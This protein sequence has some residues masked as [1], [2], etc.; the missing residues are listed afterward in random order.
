[1][2]K[3]IFLLVIFL[4]LFSFAFAEVPASDEKIQVN[5]FYSASCPHCANV[6]LTL[7][8]LEQKYD[9]IQINRYNITENY[10]LAMQ[11]YTQADI[12][13][14]EMGLVPILFVGTSYYLG[15]KPIIENL[16]REILELKGSDIPINPNPKPAEQEVSIMQLISLALVDAVNP[17][18]L[19]VLVILM[20]AILSR[21]PNNKRK[22]LKA[23]L[24]FTSAIF[25]MYLLF[26]FLI[27][28]GFKALTGLANIETLWFY[29]VLAIVAILLG[30]LNIKDAIWYGGGGFVMEVPQKWRPRMKAIIQGTTSTAGAFV[31]G[32]I[33]SFFL[34]PCT[35]GPYF[36]FGGILS[37]V[38]YLEAI[39]YL[40]IYMVLFISPMLI[41][42]GITYFG[43]MAI[44]DV[45]AWREK[46]I[47]VMHWVA[48]LL[49]LGL[50]LAMW[51]GLI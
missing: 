15:D 25:I 32:L 22:A 13:S 7:D 41:I 14:S 5:F 21:Y 42:T 49:L 29:K 18:E 23:G 39:P 1:M 48:G 40:L 28:F 43:L 34:T 20:T 16:E 26:G 31:T 46:N 12:T 35:A 6:E 11:F 3:V 30:L 19:A 37:N 27:I 4:T 38:S 17:C 8:E 47:N 50:G 45:S 9:F 33:V 10:D 36:V 44:E 2:K 51:F 24:A